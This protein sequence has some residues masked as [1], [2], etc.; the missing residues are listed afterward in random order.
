M[1][2]YYEVLGVARNVSFEDVKRQYRKLAKQ[3]HPDVNPGDKTAEIN[4][5]AINEAYNT[6]G[7]ESLRR[8]YDLKFNMKNVNSKNGSP[9]KE[10]NPNNNRGTYRDFDIK[11]LEKSFENYF[12]FKPKTKI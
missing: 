3:Y 9:K 4:F 2:N 10:T 1:K 5:I 6:L 7:N 11:N 8:D 12:G